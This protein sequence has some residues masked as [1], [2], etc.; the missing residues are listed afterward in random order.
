M[1]EEELVSAYLD[2][3]ISRRV[4]VRRLVATGVSAA[5]AA[6]LAG[7]VGPSAFAD[8]SGTAGSGTTGGTGGTRVRRK[9]GYSYGGAGGTP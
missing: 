4:F 7:L 9:G 6:S 3:H 8:G 5:A 2:G 1:S